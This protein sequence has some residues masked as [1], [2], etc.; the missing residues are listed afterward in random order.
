MQAIINQ[1]PLTDMNSVVIAN[2]Q[3]GDSLMSTH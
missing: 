3:G 1:C 2:L